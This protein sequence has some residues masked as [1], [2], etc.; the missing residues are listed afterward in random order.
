MRIRGS[1]SSAALLIINDLGMRRLPQMA[2]EDMLEIV[3]RR[4]ERASTLLT[5]L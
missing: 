2:T 3:T 4:Y 5:P 1:I